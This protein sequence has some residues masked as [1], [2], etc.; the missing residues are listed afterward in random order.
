MHVVKKIADLCTH[1][2]LLTF[3]FSYVGTYIHWNYI[4]YKYFWPMPL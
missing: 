1:V 3:Y 4:F 2:L